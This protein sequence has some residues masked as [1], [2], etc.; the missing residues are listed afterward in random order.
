MS[1]SPSPSSSPRPSSPAATTPPASAQD[2]PG[3]G[4]QL[5]WGLAVAA[6][7]FAL[8]RPVSP[9]EWLGMV[10]WQTMGALTGLL[11]ITQ[12]VERSGV[13]QGTARA[14]LA[15]TGTARQLALVLCAV[16][17]V[18]AALVTNDV[19][20][21][22]LVPLTRELAAQARLP[23]ARLVALEALAVNAGSSLTPIG[24]PQNLYLWHKTGASFG[25]FMGMMA[26]AVGVMLL[27]LFVTILI[28][29]PASRI[30]VSPPTAQAPTQPRLLLLSAVL[31]VGFVASLELKVWVP[32]LAVVVVAFALFQRQVLMKLDWAL[33]ATFVLMFV[34][35]HQLVA[36]PWMAHWMAQLPKDVAWPTYVVAILT[37]QVISNVPAT[38]LLADGTRQ[39]SALAVG[40]NVGGY[41]FV[42]GSMANLIALRLAREPHGLREFHRISLPFLVVCAVLVALLV[43]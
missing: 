9:R 33:L 2:A 43:V 11:I 40:V 31:F 7:G 3:G 26:P 15:R 25:G 42:L 38:L 36:L 22:L 35:V 28:T 30:Q 10:D 21:F 13:L 32:A 12:G 34:V 16:A 1:S 5:L 19:S 4:N 18:L 29:M 23:L 41:G 17:A 27:L 24:N 6:I 14:L 20:L 39:L 37:S 8:W